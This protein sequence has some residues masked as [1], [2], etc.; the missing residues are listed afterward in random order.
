MNIARVNELQWNCSGISFYRP[1]TVWRLLQS[2]SFLETVSCLHLWDVLFWRCSS[3]VKASQR[4]SILLISLSRKISQKQHW[5][6]AQEED[7]KLL[8]SIYQ[9][10]LLS[11]QKS[12]RLLKHRGGPASIWFFKLVL[13]DFDFSSP[14]PDL[15]SVILSRRATRWGKMTCTVM[16]WVIQ[17]HGL[18]RPTGL[19]PSPNSLTH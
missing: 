6:H 12:W 1:Q 4:S 9:G 14:H 17:H 8:S 2:A 7:F 13:L 18:W 3:C 15:P 5:N 10:R 11:K 16:I 19:G